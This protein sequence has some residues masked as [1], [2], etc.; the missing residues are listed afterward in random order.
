MWKDDARDSTSVMH[1]VTHGHAQDTAYAV[2]WAWYPRKNMWQLKIKPRE[3]PSCTGFNEV[4][5]PLKSVH[6][7]ANLNSSFSRH[8]L[9][10]GGKL[11][12]CM[13]P[14]TELFTYLTY[15]SFSQDRNN[16]PSRIPHTTSTPLPTI[17][18]A[19]LCL[20]RT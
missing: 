13:S 16:H 19:T 10:H 1:L 14:C 7:L 2:S 3:S 17:R 8:N 9:K 4:C 11:V 5:S 12:L 6:T 15:R 20:N 18:V